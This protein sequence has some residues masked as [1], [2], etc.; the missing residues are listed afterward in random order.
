MHDLK[1]ISQNIIDE[2][3]VWND[4]NELDK[5]FILKTF[6]GFRRKFKKNSFIEIT[7]KFIGN[8]KKYLEVFYIL[9]NIFK[10]TENSAYYRNFRDFAS[11]D[12]KNNRNFLLPDF[13]KN[14]IIKKISSKRYFPVLFSLKNKNVFDIIMNSNSF[15]NEIQRILSKFNIILS[16]D[17][18]VDK[19]L[20]FEIHSFLNKNIKSLFNEI[21]EIITK[22]SGLAKLFKVIIGTVF[23]T[24][25]IL[26]KIKDVNEKREKILN[27]VKI[28]YYWGITYPLVDNAED[29]HLLNDNELKTLK[30]LLFK[31]I[32]GELNKNEVP[33]TAFFRILYENLNELNKLFPKNNNPDLYYMFEV[34]FEANTQNDLVSDEK[35]ILLNMS[36]KAGLA[37]IITAYL[38]DY[39]ITDKFIYNTMLVSIFNQTD[40]DF[41]DYLED[42]GNKKNTLFTR[43]INNP[44]KFFIKYGEFL[45]YKFGD[46]KLRK[47]ILWNFIEKIKLIN[48]S[49]RR[50]FNKYLSEFSNS[51]P[52]D[53]LNYLN[54]F[55]R[56]SESVEYLVEEYPFIQFMDYSLNKFKKKSLNL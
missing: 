29:E 17:N 3:L 16:D 38:S 18:V 9:R 41:Q 19:Q 25:A 12:Y 28:G 11:V 10:N 45:A 56:H 6:K 54:Y 46:T 35:E 1:I 4:N 33:E 49:N 20:L 8:K 39:P 15:S 32:T 51:I 40:D 47:L 24:S 2:Y 22:K 50:N 27:A 48:L 53:V 26:N 23:Y 34:F 55:S 31:A 37:R 52:K 30:E 42:K 7:S 5:E 36:I 14:Q 13:Y 21:P 43:N 44:M